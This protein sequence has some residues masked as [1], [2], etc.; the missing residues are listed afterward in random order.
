MTSTPALYL[1]S[2]FTSY[3]ASSSSAATAKTLTNKRKIDPAFHLIGKPSTA[4]GLVVLSIRT[5]GIQQQENPIPPKSIAR[6]NGSST[7]TQLRSHPHHRLGNNL[8]HHLQ[9][10]LW[11]AY[12]LK[13]HHLLHAIETHPVTPRIILKTIQSSIQVMRTRTIPF[14]HHQQGIET[15]PHRS[16]SLR[17][18][19]TIQLRLSLLLIQQL[20]AHCP[21]YK[22]CHLQRHK[23]SLLSRRCHNNHL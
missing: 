17:H 19:T 13:N 10:V 15:I 7:A 18:G 14:H 22:N 6:N 12:R 1:V 21:C 5:L 20:L 4:D 23:G 3:S 11:Y 2:I 8:H 9:K 16:Y